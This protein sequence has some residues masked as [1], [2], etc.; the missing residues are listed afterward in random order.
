M[1]EL[2][3]ISSTIKSNPKHDPS[4]D[5]TIPV[6]LSTEKTPQICHRSDLISHRSLPED[7]LILHQARYNH[8]NL[9][10]AHR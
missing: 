6:H 10:V 1:R 5:M 7:Q 8:A 9:S 3:L 4:V 2:T